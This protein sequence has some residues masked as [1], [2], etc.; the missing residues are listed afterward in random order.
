M[1]NNANTL[2]ILGITF[3][4]K[5]TFKEHCLLLKKNLSTRVNVIKFLSSIK[6]SSHVTSLIRVI[7]SII[8]SKIDYGLIIYGKCA[9]STLQIIEPTYHS[10]VRLALKAY[11]TTPLKNM[12]TEAGL[13]TIAERVEYLTSRLLPKVTAPQL[14]PI[15]NDVKKIVSRSRLPKLSSTLHNALSYAK[16]LDI[17]SDIHPYKTTSHPS[18]LFKHSS[19]ITQLKA[20]PK[21]STSDETYR[22]MFYEISY[23]FKHLDWNLIFTDGSKNENGTAFAVV[24]E[25]GKTLSKGLLL[26]SSSVLSAEAMAILQ[27]IKT[28]KTK[29]KIIICT[30]SLSTITAVSNISNRTPI[31]EDIRSK[32]IV[33]ESRIKLMWVPGHVGIKGN[34]EA[35]NAAKSATHEPLITYYF[36]NKEDINKVI[37]RYW[38]IKKRESWTRYTHHYSS[39]NPQAEKALYPV[40][41]SNKAIR[42]F[43]RL[44]LGHTNLTHSYLIT[45]TQRPLC[46]FCN[47]NE[48]LS[49]QHL[50]SNCHI[51]KLRVKK[52]LKNCSIGDLLSSISEKN[53]NSLY[54]ILTTLNIQNSI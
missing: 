46:H 21:A 15:T 12:L 7:K 29:R 3:D 4:C 39:I 49:I 14:S 32:L 9:R 27:A 26:L 28:N 18:W 33:N 19:I 53:V 40:R 6:S 16:H 2:K 50:L 23:E 45:K 41:C 1:I 34:E 43:I 10:A 30:D 44:R 51:V 8:L 22:Q 37:Q 24:D 20:M 31:I 42:C 54:K 17:P 48:V 47:C 25:N 5:F 38:Q 35:D 11:R 36:H 13:Q 52:I